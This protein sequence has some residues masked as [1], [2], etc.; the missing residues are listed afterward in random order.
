MDITELHEIIEKL[1]LNQIQYSLGGSGLLFY[2]G[3]IDKVNDWDIVV[4]GVLLIT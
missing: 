4:H 3:L 1:S 2:L